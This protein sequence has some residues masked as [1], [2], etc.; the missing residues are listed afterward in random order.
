MGMGLTTFPVPSIFLTEVL[1]ASPNS[2]CLILPLIE[3]Y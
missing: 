3:A 2:V 1:Y